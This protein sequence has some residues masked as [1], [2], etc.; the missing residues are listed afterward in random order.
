MS[1]KATYFDLS[2][3]HLHL[4]YS[5]A[6]VGEEGPPLH[7]LGKAHLQALRGPIV[8]SILTAPKATWQKR[9]NKH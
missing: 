8:A 5:A 9:I 4:G 2:K 3:L 6:D 1:H 7:L